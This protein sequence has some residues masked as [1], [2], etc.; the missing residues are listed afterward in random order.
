MA[1]RW[2]DAMAEAPPRQQGD[3]QVEAA[4]GTLVLLHAPP[5]TT[6]SP[7]EASYWNSRLNRLVDA[8]QEVAHYRRNLAELEAY[9]FGIPMQTAS[10]CI[11]MRTA[12]GCERHRDASGCVADGQK[13]RHELEAKLAE[14]MQEVEAIKAQIL[15]RM[16]HVEDMLED[17][18][19][20]GAASS[21]TA[22]PPTVAA[23]PE[24][25]D[26]PS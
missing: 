2:R 6:V 15:E 14:R 1:D 16:V 7:R 19:N 10:G 5:K 13:T 9:K 18:V 8:A 24:E 12:S 11:G 17:V 25:Q 4:P 23:D 22:P 20:W 26:G 3:A 21:S